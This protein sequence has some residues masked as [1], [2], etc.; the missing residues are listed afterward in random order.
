MAGFNYG[1]VFDFN[2]NTDSGKSQILDDLFAIYTPETRET[3]L[4]A[5]SDELE[6]MVGSYSLNKVLKALS[7][8]CAEKA[9]DFSSDYSDRDSA[10]IWIRASKKI[11]NV[12]ETYPD[13]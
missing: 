12:A 4:S 2:E 6:T 7:D 13:I 11:E 3:D 5:M 8:I 10:T 9:R 1:G